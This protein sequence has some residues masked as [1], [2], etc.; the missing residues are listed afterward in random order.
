M[1]GSLVGI[2]IGSTNIKICCLDKEESPTFGVVAHEGNL[3]D[4]VSRLWQ[5][6]GL[7]AYWKS[8]RGPDQE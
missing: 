3:E 2:D 8:W 5:E 1:I 7:D 4:G 6:L